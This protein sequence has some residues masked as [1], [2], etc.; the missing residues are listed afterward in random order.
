MLP[1]A[2]VEV[3]SR[4]KHL[5]HRVDR[6]LTVHTHLKMEGSWRIESTASVT[7]RRLADHQLRAVA[8]TAKWTALGLRLGLVEVW[9]TVDEDRHLGHLGPDILGPDWDLDRAVARIHDSP[10][11]TL[12]S[13]LLDQRTLAGLG[14][15][16]TSEALYAARLPPW[17]PP[18]LATAD[19]LRALL[20]RTQRQ[21]QQA[22]A[23]GIQSTTGRTRRGETTAVHGRIG[24]PC[25]RCG[26]TLRLAPIGPPLRVRVLSY[27][28]DCQ[29]GLAPIDDGRS[30]RPLGSAPRGSSTRR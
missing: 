12:G 18:A 25:L 26:A 14:T 4:G 10:S 23:N 9:P 28:P 13:A 21:M 11:S 3:I 29:G 5:L 7:G 19:S 1:A 27:C 17:S 24:L 8:A 2:T 20:T 16:W 15:L 30:Q 22:A 6:G